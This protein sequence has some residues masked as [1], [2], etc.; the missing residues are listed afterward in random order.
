MVPSSNLQI[1]SLL[2]QATRPTDLVNLLALQIWMSCG[3]TLIASSR[4]SW[5][6]KMAAHLTKASPM[7]IL[8]MVCPPCFAT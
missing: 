1:L 5:V 6:V 8:S 2:I 4:S 7:A 3:V